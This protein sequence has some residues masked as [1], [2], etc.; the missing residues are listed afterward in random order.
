[1][2]E[3]GFVKHEDAPYHNNYGEYIIKKLC[4]LVFW[5]KKV[6]GAGLNPSE[7]G[8]F[9]MQQFPTLAQV[10]FEQGPFSQFR[11]ILL[12]TGQQTGISGPPDCVLAS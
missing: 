4:G 5:H 2:Q 11:K 10:F 6:R 7:E 9:L 3:N 12:E 8:P 1:M